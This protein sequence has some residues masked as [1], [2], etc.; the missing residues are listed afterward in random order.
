MKNRIVRFATPG[1]DEDIQPKENDVPK[2]NKEVRPQDDLY[3]YV[4]GEFIKNAK[5]PADHSSVGGFITLRDNVE[6]TMLKEF[7]SL[8]RGR[9]SDDP[10]VDKAVL[11]YRKAMEE[12]DKKRMGL[13]YVQKKLA[14][15]DGLKNLDDVVSYLPYLYDNEYD[16]PFQIG[17]DVDMKDTSRHVVMITSPSIILPDTTYYQNDA[18]KKLLSVFQDMAEKVLAFFYEEKK[19]KKI[20]KEALR[21]DKVLSTLVKSQE[22]LADYIKSYN[23]YDVEKLV[24]QMAPLKMRSFLRV[25]YGVLPK[26]VIVAEPRYF[27][28]FSQVFNEK[29][30]PL[31]LSWAKLNCALSFAPLLSEKL[32]LLAGTYSRALSGQKKSSTKEK[33]AYRL[34]NS[35]FGEPVGIYYGKKYFGEEAKNDVIQIVKDLIETYKSRLSKNTWLS[36]A[37]RKKAV[38]KLDKMVLKIGYPEKPNPR[39]YHLSFNPESSLAEIV[40]T[41]DIEE[42]RYADSLLTKDVD[43]TLWVM[44]AHLVNACYNP[45]YNDITFPAAILQAPF[46]DIH[47]KKEENYGGIGTVI[48]HEISHAFDNNGAQM[49]EFGNIHN[50]W[51][52]KDYETFREKTKAMIEEFDNLPLEGGK[53]NGKLVVSENIADNGGVASSLETMERNITKPD[54]PAFFLNYARIWCTKARPERTRLLLTI[55]V[56]APC[57]YRADMQVRNF[58]QFYKAFSVK[59][60]DKMYLP[61]DKR[62]IIW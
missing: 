46:Y 30:V 49:D 33:Y 18:G 55:D 60:G 19:A 6:K 29:T 39:Y 37:T 13:P 28:N 38:V 27:E 61:E 9:K 20:V 57:Y 47:Q 44:D 53:V 23:P 35:Y 11:L 5:I 42:N 14:Y 59:E 24:S 17:V 51:T 7:K 26:K 8:A 48:G 41:L 32:R 56:H 36:E 34:A 50:W 21:F 15:L 62:V 22:E 3:E 45:S 52:K 31:Y 25:R 10:L 16:L 4:N 2:T 58:P 1:I 54:Y 12:D 43:R 40:D